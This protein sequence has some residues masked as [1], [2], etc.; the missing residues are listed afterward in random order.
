MRVHIHDIETEIELLPYNLYLAA[1]IYNTA[2]MP[3]SVTKACEPSAE[4]VY[5]QVNGD[6]A[7]KE[8]LPLFERIWIGGADRGVPDNNKMGV[9]PLGNR[10]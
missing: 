10:R 1:A 7:K 5:G 8:K 9:I 4:R 2:I 6:R 3:F